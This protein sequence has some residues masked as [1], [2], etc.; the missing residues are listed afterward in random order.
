MN[1]L[2]WIVVTFCFGLITFVVGWLGGMVW[3][4]TWAT[5]EDDNQFA[6]KH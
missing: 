3:E 1:T 5:D 6:P 4:R 2:S